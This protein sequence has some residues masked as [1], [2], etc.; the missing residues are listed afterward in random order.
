ME[1]CTRLA[2]GERYQIQGWLRAGLTLADIAQL[3]G[4][5]KSTVSREVSRN[6]GREG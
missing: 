1:A 5:H 2:Q 4:V 3:L 6:G